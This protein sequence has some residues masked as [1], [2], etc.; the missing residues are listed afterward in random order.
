MNHERIQRVP[1]TGGSL[2]V[3]TAGSGPALVYLHGT[4]DQG[5]LLPVLRTLSV[6]HFVV[7]PDHPGFIE[8]DDIAP[9][10]DHDLGGVR[11]MAAVHEHLLDTLGVEEFVLVGCSLGG[12]T[13][14]E[15]ALRIPDRVTR[16]VLIDP[17]GLPGDGSA[18]NIF[19]LDAED[20]LSATVHDPERRAAA[21]AAARQ[22]DPTISARIARSVARARSIASDP[23]M[24]DPTLAARLGA[25]KMPVDIVW[26]REDG[27]VP[28]SYARSWTDALPQAR[29]TIVP[30]AG[31]L[32]HVEKPATFLEV[33]ETVPTWS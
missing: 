4:G 31:H 20:T 7:R 1:L 22:G 18:P 3:I 25:L 28:V 15:L 2:R 6:N 5:E 30:E 23:Y 32:P 14:A 29:L 8:S 17:A 13:A 33:M 10:G 21:R 24:H 12:W 11:G 26:G 27:I 16:L 9:D 19:E